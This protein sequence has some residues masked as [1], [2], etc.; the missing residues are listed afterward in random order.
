MQV[1][2]SIT[3]LHRNKYK[4]QVTDGFLQI[5]YGDQDV[6]ALLTARGLSGVRLESAIRE[7]EDFGKVDITSNDEGEFPQ[8]KRMGG[9]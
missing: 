7:L 6:R 8:E 1:R 9:R 5:V 3:Q 4:F 2:I